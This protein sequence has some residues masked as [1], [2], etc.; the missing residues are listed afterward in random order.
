MCVNAVHLTGR[1]LRCVFSNGM[2]C[3]SQGN[4]KSEKAVLVGEKDSTLPP[5]YRWEDLVS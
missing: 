2:H 1:I 4:V 5:G 3:M